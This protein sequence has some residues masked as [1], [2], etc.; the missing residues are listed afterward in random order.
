MINL[1]CN[2]CGC[3]CSYEWAD[4]IVDEKTSH[5][6]CQNCFANIALTTE[7]IWRDNCVATIPVLEKGTL[8]RID[9]AEHVWH[10]GIGI[11]SNKKYGHY[12]LEINGANLWVPAH[13]VKELELSNSYT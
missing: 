10:G 12:R 11:I 4:L 2:N 8:V 6:L 9:N 3:V 13:W 7:S 1:T 5:F